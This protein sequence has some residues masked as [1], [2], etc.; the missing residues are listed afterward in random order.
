MTDPEPLPADLAAAL[1][2]D[3]AA[4]AAFDRLAPSHR[5]EYVQW[6]TEAKRAETRARRVVGTLDRL[7]EG[8]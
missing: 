1:A 3:P 8:R 5:R 6:I 7:R 2:G 4:A